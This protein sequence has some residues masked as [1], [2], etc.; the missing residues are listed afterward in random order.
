VSSGFIRSPS[1]P[2]NVLPPSDSLWT[3]LTHLDAAHDTH[4]GR[5]PD[6]FPTWE[7]GPACPTPMAHQ[8]CSATFSPGIHHLLPSLMI[9]AKPEA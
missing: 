3:V 1:S 8:W 5:P 4:Y 2:S 7:N 6:I 9:F